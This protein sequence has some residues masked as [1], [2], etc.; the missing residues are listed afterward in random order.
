MTKL[1]RDARV[2]MLSH[3]AIGIVESASR[4]VLKL[5]GPHNLLAQR[6]FDLEPDPPLPARRAADVPAPA[7]LHL[8]HPALG[9]RPVPRH[10]Y[11]ARVILALLLAAPCP[12]GLLH[13]WCTHTHSHTYT[14]THSPLQTATCQRACLRV[15]KQPTGRSPG[16]STRSGTNPASNRAGF[17]HIFTPLAPGLAC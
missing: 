4:R 7:R 8:L 14:R 2:A 6:T 15:L 17:P 3:H 11:G 9:E 13:R 12:C 16:A 1:E 5:L 10:A